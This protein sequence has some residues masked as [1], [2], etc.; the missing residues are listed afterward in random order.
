MRRVE[1]GDIHR[2]EDNIK[3]DLMKTGSDVWT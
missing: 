3:T 1:T 2:S